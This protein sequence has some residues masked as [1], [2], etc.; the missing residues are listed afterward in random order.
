MFA[1]AVIIAFF[2][3][4]AFALAR[5]SRDSAELAERVGMP[6]EK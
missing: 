3:L 6:P 5:T 4:L 1:L 2:V